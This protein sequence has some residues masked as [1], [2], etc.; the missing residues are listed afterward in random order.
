MTTAVETGLWQLDATRSTIAI[1]H[2]T[3]W[4]MVTVK[5]TFTGVS[6][7]GEVRPD[8]TVRG[9]VTLDAASLDTQ[10]KKRDEHLRSADFFD[11]ENHP[12]LVFAVRDGVFRRNGVVEVEGRLTV[13]GVSRPQTVT[14]QVTDSSADAVTLTTEFTVDRDQFGMGWNRLGMMRGLTTVTSTLRFTRTSA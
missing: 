8:G 5:G 14:V 13:R 3:M 1:S 4:G 6:G 10:H 9:A 7:E 12:T 2:A 11:V